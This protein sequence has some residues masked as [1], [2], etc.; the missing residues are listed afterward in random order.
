MTQTPHNSD[1][2]TATPPVA[3]SDPPSPTTPAKAKRRG[4]PKGNANAAKHGLRIARRGLQM[5][6]LP[7]K[8]RYLNQQI[9]IYRSRLE[10]A[11]TAARGEINLYDAHLIQTATTHAMR[12]ELCHRYVTD[13]IEQGT[14]FQPMELL[15]YLKAIG[16]ARDARDRCLSKLGLD[17]REAITTISLFD[18]DAKQP[19]AVL[20][21]HNA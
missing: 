15:A 11:V 21:T 20:L 3:S 14:T 10:E 2:A 4:P 5:Q 1:A 7:K 19:A 16:D 6:R 12:A 8:F 9:L 17:Q 13:E 18:D